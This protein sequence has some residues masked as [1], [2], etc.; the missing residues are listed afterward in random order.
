M[1]RFFSGMY[2][3]VDDYDK[4]TREIS[5]ILKARGLDPEQ[6]LTDEHTAYL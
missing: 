2:V 1:K 4:Q 6:L 3:A 5:A